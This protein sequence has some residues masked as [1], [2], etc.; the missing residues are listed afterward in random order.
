LIIDYGNN[1]LRTDKNIGTIPDPNNPTDPNAMIGKTTGALIN[2]SFQGTG[3]VNL[4]LFNRL[5]VGMDIPVNLMADDGQPAVT[6]WRPIAL[7]S[8]TL[9]FLGL[10]AKL[11]L[12]RVDKTIGLALAVQGGFGLT[13]ASRY[14]GGDPSGGS[15]GGPFVW[16]IAI[17]EKRFG[18]TGRFKTG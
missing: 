4:G 7:D 8:Q 3:Q 10:H 18:A 1:L 14:A 9:G 5:V 13:N 16:P 17:V 15:P 12:T 11:R 2:H 6:G